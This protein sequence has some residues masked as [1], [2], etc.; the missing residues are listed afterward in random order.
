MSW[1]RSMANQAAATLENARLLRELR[2]AA[3]TDSVTGVYSH[4]HLQDRLRQEVARAARSRAPL[5]VL[6]IDLDDF[7]RVNDDHGHQAGDRVLRAIASALRTA[8]RAGDVVARYGGDEFV[9]LMP[10]T[11]EV[12]AVLVAER[13]RAAV[14]SLSHPVA[15]GPDVRVSCS[16]GL[17][18]HPR[19]GKNGREL[20]RSADAAMYTQKRAR[21]AEARLRPEAG[22]V[23]AEGRGMAGPAGGAH[24][25]QA[26]ASVPID[27]KR[28][29]A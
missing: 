6:M 7:K 12:D 15:D 11:A 4:R 1:L 17:A 29:T 13:A 20:L 2:D 23:G 21:W 9:V 8:V 26:P 22:H 19:D 25:A 10:D 16:A 14:S 28:V 18:L 24:A 27:V 5:S 3:E